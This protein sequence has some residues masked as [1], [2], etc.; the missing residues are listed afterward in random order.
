MVENSSLEKKVIQSYVKRI[1]IEYLI[2]NTERFCE[3]GFLS[4]QN[5]LTNFENLSQMVG[6]I[7]SQE[8]NWNSS[9][10]SIDFGAKM[11]ITLNSC[12]SFYVKLYW[13]T[14]YGGDDRI[15]KFASNII[16]KAKYDFKERAIKI[17][18]KI[19]SMLGFQH[20]SLHE[21]NKNVGMHIDLS[22][23]IV[24]VKGNNK[25]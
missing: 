15:A 19:S 11:F 14:I 16:R 2:K 7:D 3:N 9:R 10:S 8:V 20:I 25:Y 13:K 22:K 21:G 5:I 18:A 24:D 23:N 6:D 17:F 1:R 4:T 12:P